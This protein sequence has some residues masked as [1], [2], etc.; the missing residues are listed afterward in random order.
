MSIGFA[1]KIGMT[2][3]YV[4]GISTPVTV[5]QM[6]TTYVLEIKTVEKHGYKAVQV[7][8]I[9]KRK[10]SK[11]ALNHVKKYQPELEHGFREI[12]EFQN[13]NLDESVKSIDISQFAVNTKINITGKTIGR[14]YTG[15]MKRWGFHGQPQTHGHDHPR[16]VGS[17]GSRWPQR[18]TKGKKMAGHHGNTNLTLN[19]VPILAIDDE[20]NLLFI[21]GSIP[22]ANSSYVSFQAQA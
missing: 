15:A 9:K 16:A 6:E 14:G 11:A 2:R 13:V 21:K 20:K 8:A 22:G 12:I 3:I 18:V 7:G 4:D 5:L 19:G 17:M 1:K 10:V